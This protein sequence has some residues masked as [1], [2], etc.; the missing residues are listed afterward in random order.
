MENKEALL[1]IEE[2]IK[3]KKDRRMYERLQTIRLRLVGVSVNG[4]ARFPVVLRKQS[5]NT[6]MPTKRTVSLV[7][8]YGSHQGDPL[9]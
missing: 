2:R 1:A 5:V 9:D 8:T 3:L 4:I 7:S 6:F